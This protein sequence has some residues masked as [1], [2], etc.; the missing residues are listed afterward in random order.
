MPEAMAAGMVAAMMAEGTAAM[1]EATAAE[2]VAEV[3]AAAVVVIDRRRPPGNP[4]TAYINRFRPISLI[5]MSSLMPR[6]TCSQRHPLP[7]RSTE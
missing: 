2:A 7:S 4:K 6:T 5:C 3:V 1:E